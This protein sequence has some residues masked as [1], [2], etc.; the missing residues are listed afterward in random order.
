MASS[1]FPQ[2]DG[3]F[4]RGPLWGAS[5]DLCY[6]HGDR[7]DSTDYVPVRWIANVADLPSGLRTRNQNQLLPIEFTPTA[8][9]T[10]SELDEIDGAIEFVLPTTWLH[11][12]LSCIDLDKRPGADER[13]ECVILKPDISAKTVPQ[14]Q[15]LQQDN[16]NLT[17]TFKHARNKGRPRKFDVLAELEGKRNRLSW[18]LKTRAD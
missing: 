5:F 14:I 3:L 17:P 15:L 2:Q 7:C 12:V 16:G 1:T 18:H 8:G 11:L 13:I 4:R 9:V 6:P 10:V